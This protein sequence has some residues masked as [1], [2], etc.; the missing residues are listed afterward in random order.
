MGYSGIPRFEPGL[1]LGDQERDNLFEALSSLKANPYRHYEGFC[2]QVR[3]VAGATATPSALHDYISRRRTVSQAAEPIGIIKNVPIDHELPI[4]DFDE[5]VISKYTRKKT[6][7]AEGF[8]ALY[9]EIAGTPAISYLNV[10]DGD[11]FQDIYPKRSL[12]ASQSQKAVGPIYFHKD[13]ANH[14]VR[15]DYVYMIG[16]R[17]GGDNEVLTT[18]VN[19]HD[20]IERLD[21]GALVVAQQ[22]RFRTPFDDL[23]VH[24]GNVPLGAADEHPLI[25][26]GWDLRIFENRTVGL[27]EE[28]KKVLEEVVSI[29][30]QVKRGI[31]IQPGDFVITCNNYC[32]HSKEIIRLAS[33][34]QL[35]VRWLI[36][37]VNVDS[38]APHSSHF[39]DG[40]PYLVNG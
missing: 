21:E 29:L 23:S 28:A 15:P 14:Y 4:F 6:F 37:T 27:D 13:L 2:A 1:T 30:H 33:R 32:V 31:D 38:R 20:V 5:P 8:L 7:V 25:A 16:M 39:V 10:N 3:R 36:K 34:E 9:A 11:V 12:L 24:G 19:N 40:V 22:R 17:S 35:Q 18:F 26:S